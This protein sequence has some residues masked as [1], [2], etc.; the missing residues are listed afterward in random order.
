MLIRHFPNFLQLNRENLNICQSLDAEFETLWTHKD[1]ILNNAF[2]ND[3]DADGVARFENVVNIVPTTTQT[4]DE[5]KAN[6]LEKMNEQLP[7]TLNKLRTR[8]L[9]QCGQ[10]NFS[11]ELEHL[12][13]LLRVKITIKQDYNKVCD[14][15][16]TMIPCNL[17]QNII[18]M[19][20]SHRR[21]STKTHRELSKYT[22][23][24]IR[25]MEATDGD[26]Q[27]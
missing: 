14:I 3:S 2:V 17:I 4:L 12:N 15:V 25:E 24:Q 20:E 10:G 8:L 13:Y 27:L 18:V 21:L 26:Y 9:E 19:Y 11:I 22:H 6:I 23:R 1:Q 5:R 7:Y 16:D